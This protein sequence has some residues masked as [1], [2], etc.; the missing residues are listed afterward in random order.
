M[1]TPGGGG[2]FD[3]SSNRGDDLLFKKPKPVGEKVEVQAPVCPAVE[4]VCEEEVNEDDILDLPPKLYDAI[5]KLH[6][7][8]EKKGEAQ[9]LF[10]QFAIKLCLDLDIRDRDILRRALRQE[11]KAD[12]VPVRLGKIYKDLLGL[13]EIARELGLTMCNI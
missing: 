13:H 9:R 7:E 12:D 1:F 2:F 6:E 8:G 5:V 10:T 11:T 4:I 3:R